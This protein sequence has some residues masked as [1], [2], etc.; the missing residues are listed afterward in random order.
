MSDEQIEWLWI[1]IAIV[2][3]S[4]IVYLVLDLIGGN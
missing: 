3:G 1:G 2:V 4:S